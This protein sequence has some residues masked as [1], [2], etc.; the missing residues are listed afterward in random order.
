MDTRINQVRGCWADPFY[1]GLLVDILVAGGIF[2]DHHRIL[3]PF[4]DPIKPLLLVDKILGAIAKTYIVS[5]NLTH[6][7]SKGRIKT[8]NSSGTF[9][10]FLLYIGGLL[11]PFCYLKLKN[12]PWLLSLHKL[13][14]TSLK[15]SL[16]TLW[17]LWILVTWFSFTRWTLN[18]W[19][20]R[21]VRLI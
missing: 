11:E 20:I 21:H 2:G 8:M 4:M 3:H 7:V 9:F 13:R 17:D 16:L 19:F 15:I 5:T 18:I 1:S 10:R 12:G 14:I 6:K